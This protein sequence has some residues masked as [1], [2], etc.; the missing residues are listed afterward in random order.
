MGMQFDA[1]V[2]NPPYM[3]GKGMNPALKDY[4][5]SG[6]I[7]LQGLMGSVQA[8]YI[9]ILANDCAPAETELHEGLSTNTAR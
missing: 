2:A 4:A 9:T 5:R 6:P 7:G 3:G 1:V 8:T